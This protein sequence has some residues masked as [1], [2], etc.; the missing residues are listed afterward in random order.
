MASQLLLAV[1]AQASDLEPE[2]LL[3]FD[4]TFFLTKKT[5]YED[6]RKIWKNL[7]TLKFLWLVSQQRRLTIQ[8]LNGM[9]TFV[10]L[11][12]QYMPVV[13]STCRLTSL[14]TIQFHPHLS[15]YLQKYPIQTCLG[16]LFAWI[17]FKK[18]R[19]SGTKDGLQLT[20]FSQFWSNYKVSYLK[21]QRRSKSQENE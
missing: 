20:Q 2:I 8:Y 10:D 21:S 12:T 19:K 11:L 13:S 5:Q 18:E 3:T 7:K 4:P 14:R 15:L 17:C 9:Q 6:Y 16:R 1:V